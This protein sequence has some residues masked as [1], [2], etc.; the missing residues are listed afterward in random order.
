MSKFS[1]LAVTT[2]VAVLPVMA[3]SANTSSVQS[4]KNNSAPV[5]LVY[6]QAPEA[7]NAEKTAALTAK[8][9]AGDVAAQFSLANQYYTGVGTQKDRKKALHWYMEAAKQGHSMAQYYIGADFYE[10]KGGEVEMPKAAFWLK[11][12]AA[13]QEPRAQ[14]LLAWMYWTGDGVEK[15]RSEAIK[16]WMIASNKGYALSQIALG[17]RYWHGE[18]VEEDAEEAIKMYKVAASQGNTLAQEVLAERYWKGGKIGR[19]LSEAYRLNTLAADKESAK[20][21]YYL[22]VEYSR[23]GDFVQRDYGTAKELFEK[24]ANQ[25]FAKSERA[26]AD[27]YYSGRGVQK[28]HEEARRL[29]RLAA[30]KGDRQAIEKLQER[31][32]ETVE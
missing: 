32:L 3:A 31:F 7:S 24:S 21:M 15:S 16:L 12:S 6:A 2:V 26:L 10:G 18:G 20:A 29:Y 14:H 1:R 17:D 11:K 9:E 8:A 13:D 30:S 22:G 27:V 23:G 19:N 4:L 28:N 5:E 25:G